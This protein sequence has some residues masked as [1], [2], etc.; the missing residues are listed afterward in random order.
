MSVRE[1]FRV[2]PTQANAKVVLFERAERMNGDAQNALLK[3]LEEPP[4]FARIILVAEGSDKLLP[5]IRSRCLLINCYAQTDPQ[6]FL[7]L[8]ERGEVFSTQEG[9]AWADEFIAFLGGFCGARLVDAL[10]LSEAFQTFAERYK[11]IAKLETER[12]ANAETVRLAATWFGGQ[13]PHHKTE[14]WLSKL[15]AMHGQV[16][17]NVNFGYLCDAFFLSS[18]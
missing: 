12:A 18:L 7:A 5:T 8:G 6:T 11:T 2:G 4:A 3:V 13:E 9:Q 14:E 17:G 15:I 1:F 16:Q 10:V